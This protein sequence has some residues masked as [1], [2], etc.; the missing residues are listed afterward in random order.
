MRS[1]TSLCAIAACFVLTATARAAGVSGDGVRQLTAPQAIADFTLTDQDGKPFHFRQLKGNPVLL[2]FGF[3]RCPDACPTALTQM[4]AV[5]R[6]ADPGLRATRVVMVSIDGERDSPALMKR[7]VAA[8]SP[9][10]IGLT[11]DPKSVATI[12]AQF[13]AVFFKGLPYDRAGNYL[14]QHTT[15]I[16]LLDRSGRLRSSFTNASTDAIADLTRSVAREKG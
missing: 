7:Y 1:A 6:R 4:V 13:S 2:F 16:Y 9:G 15:Q 14:V 12:A 10:V 3:T 5:A 11:G 8:L